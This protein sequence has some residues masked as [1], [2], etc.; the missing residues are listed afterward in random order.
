MQK[1]LPF[2]YNKN[3][4]TSY[5]EENTVKNVF[6]LL[7]MILAIPLNAFAFD[8]RGWWQLEYILSIWQYGGAAHRISFDDDWFWL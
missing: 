6:V 1:I 7:L 8:I 4:S 3:M 2:A 5:L